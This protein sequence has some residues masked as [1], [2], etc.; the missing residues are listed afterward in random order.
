MAI[1]PAVLVPAPEP[2]GLRY[3][4]LT[5]ANG[6]LNL[7]E[8]HGR[9]GDVQYEPVSCG[10]A[11]RWDAT[12]EPGGEKTFDPND[13]VISAELFVVYATLQCGSVGHTNAE[14]EARVRRRLANGEQTAAEAGLAEALASVAT[15]LFAPDPTDDDSVIGALEQWL[16]GSNPGQQ[17]YGN[18]GY[19]HSPAR[20]AGY[21]GSGGF[22]VRDGN[23]WRTHMGTV[24]VFGGGYPDDGTMWITG[25]VTVWRS[26]DVHV[27]SPEQTFN[28]TTNQHTLL[29]ER[30]YA[31]G[32]DC[33][34]A[35]INFAPETDPS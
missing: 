22:L 28:R 15:P 29:A 17:Q 2:R 5:A 4:L 10:F 6:P 11:R 3:G 13:P 12:C 16:Y 24:V 8:G 21:L 19:I 34:A 7:P 1:V 9:G 33:H 18:V 20:Y 31:V 30:E 27:P 25:Q 23:V 26:E 14:M 35:R 32:F